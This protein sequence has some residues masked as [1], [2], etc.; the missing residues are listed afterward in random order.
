MPDVYPFRNKFYVSEA[1]F[2]LL[3]RLCESV[4]GKNWTA[5]LKETILDPLGMKSTRLSPD[6]FSI[7]NVALPY[8]LRMGADGLFVQQDLQI[9]KYV[10]VH[11][12]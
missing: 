4:A 5:L 2:V 3:S 12:S 10:T 11:V 9:F 6:A 7:E 8:I 1:L